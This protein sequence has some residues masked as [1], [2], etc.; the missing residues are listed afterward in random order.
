MFTER[1]FS[2]K[3]IFEVSKKFFPNVNFSWSVI[4]VHL[5]MFIEAFSIYCCY[6]CLCCYTVATAT[7]DVFMLLVRWW[8]KNLPVKM[9]CFNRFSFWKPSIS[10]VMRKPENSGQLSENLQ[11]SRNE[12]IMMKLWGIAVNF[13][14]DLK[15]LKNV[16]FQFPSFRQK[17]FKIV[18]AVCRLF[19][20]FYW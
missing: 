6:C 16:C 14:I 3:H 8:K 11:K 13:L 1:T 12:P 7:F 9:H 4:D 20:N 18:F 15:G 17:S 10:R 2:W 5:H 19:T